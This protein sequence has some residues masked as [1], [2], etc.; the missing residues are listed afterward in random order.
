[1]NDKRK[2]FL[3][4][5]KI[6]IDFNIKPVLSYIDAY[7]SLIDKETDLK[8]AVFGRF[9]AGKSSFLNSLS[10]EDILPIGVLPVTGI[11]TELYWSTSFKA[12][13]VFSDGRTLPITKNDIPLY[14]SQE[15]NS[16]NEKNVES[17]R[18]GVP[19][20]FHC[21]GLVFVD[22]PGIDSIFRDNTET[23]INWL[24]KAELAILAISADSPFSENDLE[25][26]KKISQHCP[27]IDILITKADILT[28][29]EI[30]KIINFVKNGIKK[31]LSLD[32]RVYPY[33][34]KKDNSHFKKE[35]LESSIY[36]MLK[37]L[38]TQKEAVLAHKLENTHRYCLQYLSA[39]LA[40]S[41]KNEKDR[42]NYK[43]LLNEYRT[44]FSRIKKDFY[45][46]LSMRIGENRSYLEKA[47]LSHK[48]DI[49]KEISLFL[50]KEV[51]S[52][53]KNLLETSKIY[54]R[55]MEK[56]LS[57]R[58]L[59]IFMREKDKIEKI[60]NNYSSDFVVNANDFCS[61]MSSQA[62]MVLGEKLPDL[63]MEYLSQSVPF[64]DIKISQPFD[65]HIELLWFLIPSR[66][67]K[68]NIYSHFLERA[69]F[70]V[71]K[72][73]IRM[74]MKISETTQK[75]IENTVKKSLEHIQSNLNMAD[76]ILSSS[77]SDLKKIKSA[78]EKIKNL[79]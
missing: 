8:I 21:K 51:F 41:E 52:Q 74:A 3:E 57:E 32:T 9:K 12:E 63:D 7:R 61:K 73:L 11:I 36:P 78:I 40:V 20:L 34:V 1:M 62:S 14:V 33:S 30:L 19:G 45:T 49:Q 35:F 17:V 38:K 46:L 58:I 71:E 65:S 5:E 50:E 67:F 68:R 25:L 18:I 79:Q 44:H 42:E 48:K 26:L 66:L 31:N 77:T 4:L 22:T 29:E 13:I 76:K 24:P 72:N 54:S 15:N 2:L 28:E 37:D 53:K 55:Y 23:S 47:F 69:N 64:Q 10:G 27:K 39:I 43:S 59:D 75:S 70:E 16:G 6:A 60:L 56:F